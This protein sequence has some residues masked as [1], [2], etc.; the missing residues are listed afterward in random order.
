MVL[1]R[2]SSQQSNRPQWRWAMGNLVPKEH[3]LREIDAMIDFSFIHDRVGGL[4]C[5][6]H[7]RPD[8]MHSGR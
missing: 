7:D 5:P 1:H 3:R 8:P 4:Y 2:K 6:D